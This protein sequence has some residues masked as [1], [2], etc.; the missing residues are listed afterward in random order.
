M[1]KYIVML[2]MIFSGLILAQNNPKATT[3][4]SRDVTVM[5]EKKDVITPEYATITIGKGGKSEKM[6]LFVKYTADIT[7][8]LNF[9]KDPNEEIVT[10]KGNKCSRFKLFDGE[11]HHVGVYIIN[12]IKKEMVIVTSTEQFILKVK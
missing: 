4:T 2:A 11:G 3:I 6:S 9:I 10:I 8:N 7:Y 5:T 1:K 12:N